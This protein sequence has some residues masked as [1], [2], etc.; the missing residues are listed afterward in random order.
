MKVPIGKIF[1]LLGPN[2]TGKTTLI[3]TILGR[4]RCSSGSVKVFG[5]R[6]GTHESDIPGPGVGYMPQEL[7]LF[8][9]FTIAECLT[10]YGTIYHIGRD[11]I[12]IRI[13]A[14]I[15]LLNLPEK[16]RPVGRLS[17]GQQRRVSIA[18]TMIHK[19][20]LIILDEPTV[21]VDSLLRRRIW[22][23]LEDICK[24]FGQ[25]VI[26]TTHY[27]EEARSASTV[28]FMNNGTILKQSDPNL[29]MS[30]YQC[31]T[32]EDVFLRLCQTDI[33]RR[34]SRQIDPAILANNFNNDKSSKSDDTNDLIQ[35]HDS[36]VSNQH[37]FNNSVFDLTRI[38]AMCWKY[39]TLTKRRPLFLFGF[40]LI[41]MIALITMNLTIS[42]SPYNIPVAIY[43]QD[44]SNDGRLSQLFIDS[45]DKDYI[46][47]N[48]FTDNQS[49]YDSIVAGKNSLSIVFGQ[50][51]SD[52]FEIRANDLFDLSD[53]EV[54]E[55]GIKVYI[56]FSDAAIGAF[57]LKYLLQ[58][59]KSFLDSLTVMLGKR[60]LYRALSPIHIVET[61]YGD[62]SLDVTTH[63]GPSIMIVLAQVLPMV[64]SA[65]Q[66]VSDRKN[67]SFERVFVAGVKPIEYFIAHMLQQ[68]IMSVVLVIMCMAIAFGVFQLTQIGSYFEIFIMLFLQT[69]VG[70]SIGLLGALVM[71][72]EVSVAVSI[73]GFMLPLWIM[74]GVL[75]PLEAIPAYFLYASKLSPIT[76]PLEGM[77]SVMLRGWSYNR[78]VVFY[79]YFVSLSYSLI[80]SLLNIILFYKFTDK[81]FTWNVW[82]SS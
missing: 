47:L 27:I 32:L 33:Q 56:D 43:N 57:V 28:A 5:L 22:D 49:A 15:E 50:N 16:T 38:R 70:I 74:S 41:P 65:F 9:E 67:S 8:E 55:S 78:P 12:N 10:Y 77:R 68:L 75:W 31:S 2:G 20:K 51:F 3:R 54:D 17:G 36:K 58:A 34:K 7:A 21:G 69:V 1:A 23:Y 37:V 13:D 45:I 4:L 25:T 71:A 52:A 29:L 11:D 24:N 40:Y 42:K 19:P 30:Q 18:I 46:A 44:V 35:K 61:I 66:I 79:G 59:F 62:S 80:V 81:A 60:D 76:I 82:K 48:Y 63:F 26:I 6:T 64:L 72:D 73:S 14:L 39:Y 53:D